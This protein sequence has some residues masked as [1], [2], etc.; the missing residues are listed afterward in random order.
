MSAVFGNVG[1]SA[2]E[3]NDFH[4]NSDADKSTLAQHHTLGPQPNQASP[5]D[6]THD[7]KTSKKLQLQNIQGVSVSYTPVGHALSTS[8]TFNGA[9]LITGSYTKFG[10]L[11]HFQIAVDYS[12]ILTFG[13]GQYYLTLPF[14][15]E[16][17]YIFRDGCLHD[18]STSNQ[19]AV[20]G[21]VAA[22]SSNLYLFSVASNGRDVPFEHNVPVTLDVADNF[23]IAGTYEILP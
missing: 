18:I 5:G 8:P 4:S 3:V 16:H 13:T 6:H 11:L 23:H 7:G 2:G 19:Y 17:A 20:T 21:H 22:G 9:T 14:A 10:N 15:A 1:A 12:N